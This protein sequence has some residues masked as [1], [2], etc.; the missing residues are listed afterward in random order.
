MTMKTRAPDGSVHTTR[1]VRVLLPDGSIVYKQT[2]PPQALLGHTG[3]WEFRTDEAGTSLRSTHTIV[4]DPAG[5]AEVFGSSVS[6]GDAVDRLRA[7]LSA[8][9]RVTMEHAARYSAAIGA[10]R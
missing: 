8:N 6:A 5:A 3:R 4:V 7:A 1:S 9:S 10:S 2:Q